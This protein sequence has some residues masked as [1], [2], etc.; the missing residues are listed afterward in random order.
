V[1]VEFKQ[2]T[3]GRDLLRA[4]WPNCRPSTRDAKLFVDL[5]EMAGAPIHGY[6]AGPKTVL[7]APEPTLKKMRSKFRAGRNPLVALL[8]KE[9]D[10]SELVIK[11]ASR[12]VLDQ[13]LE[14]TAQNESQLRADESTDE[15]A[16]AMLLDV[17]TVSLDLELGTPAKLKVAIRCA[18]PKN[19]TQLSEMTDTGRGML[20][21]VARN[22]Q[23]LNDLPP[24]VREIVASP[25]LRDFART[26]QTVQ[27]RD[28]IDVQFVLP[29]TL[30]D[31]ARQSA[32]R[33]AGN[34]P[35]IAVDPSGSSGG[36]VQQFQWKRKQSPVE[37]I[38]RDEGFAF[39]TGVQGALPT[40]SEVSIL[41]NPAGMWRLTGTDHF[42]L[43]ARAAAMPWFVEVE[44]PVL[45]IWKKG[46]AD[47]PKLIHQRDGFCVLLKIGGAFNGDGEAFNLRVDSDGYWALRA[48]S[49]AA[50]TRLRVMVAKFKRPGSFKG[51]AREHRWK[52]GEARVRLIHSDNGFAFLSRLTGTFAG[53]AEFARVSIYD[54][55]YWY[56]EGRTH[57]R[58][59]A[60]RA[61]SIQLTPTQAG[62]R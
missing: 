44:E 1:E 62:S 5:D 34:A 60:A 49:S 24:D 15:T 32:R 6:V 2:T 27:K 46:Q 8:G 19:A 48:R 25:A 4:L 30:L 58:S 37:M 7:I 12:P 31:L 33:L 53:G 14:M 23:L 28:S 50:G 39:L 16:K 45:K 20:L 9:R 61:M 29:K 57:Q 22:Q 52:K 38:N 55:G 21:T 13:V 47:F 26:M 40:G 41:P 43:A 18:E 36:A 54:D 56:L 35:E 17:R 11:Y 3:S 42:D 10:E 51:V 59:L